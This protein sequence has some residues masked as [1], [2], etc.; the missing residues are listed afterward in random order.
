MSKRAVESSDESPAERRPDDAEIKAELA[1]IL[2][3][4]CFSQAARSSEFLRFVVEQTLAGNGARLKG[5]T[6]ALEVFGRPEDF[7]AQSDPLV[8][9]EAGRLRRRLMEYYVLEGQTNPLRI[10]L[11]LG[12]YA[13]A[14]RYAP[15]AE[16]KTAATRPIGR[17]AA[18]LRWRQLG[19]ITGFAIVAALVAATVLLWNGTTELGPVAEPS[20]A[21]A[22]TILAMPTGPRILVLPF[23]N[24][25]GDRTLDYFA[26]G[27]TEEIMLRLGDSDLFVIASQ[28]TWYYRNAGVRDESLIT[29]TDARYVLTGSVR[30]MPDRVRITARLVHAATSEQLWTEAYDEQL[31]VAILLSIQERIARQV[32]ET[33]AVPYGPIFEQE[34]A[35]AARKQP[36]HLD[37]YDCVLKYYAYRRTIEPALHLETAACFQRAVAREPGF[38]DAWAG[39]ALMYLDE[40][41]F[42]YSAQP[43]AVD[44]LD[45]AQEAARTAMDIDGEDYLA[46]LALARVR[47]FAGD[48]AGFARSADR[49]LELDPNNAEALALIGTL[50]AVS[51][52]SERA[53]PLVDKALALSPRPPGLYYV[54]RAVTDIRAG[55]SDEALAWALRIDSPNW[56]IAPM[57]V[58]AAAGLAGRDE[59]AQRSLARLLELYPAFPQYAREELAKWQPDDELLDALLRGLRAAGLEIG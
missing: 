26:D 16:T 27:V 46:N 52:V 21:R 59:V 55:R 33:I 9:V 15:A 54:A 7:D 58:T 11:P 34:L 40:H 8:R 2:G 51:G 44:A 12:G 45:R 3:S 28:T 56:F 30:H 32:V 29:E 6:I 20:D 37:T 10:E 39:L 42:G 38:A 19:I 17:P 57:I 43:A 50:L 24:I 1:R 13:A 31:S 14:F 47:F 4:R 53:L 22:D 25:S 36:E 48:F 35:R 23:E 18:V 41:A 49:V 5:Y